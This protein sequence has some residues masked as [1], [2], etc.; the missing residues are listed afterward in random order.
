MKSITAGD[1]IQI[2]VTAKDD[3]SGIKEVKVK[4]T[5]IR[6]LPGCPTFEIEG[7]SEWNTEEGCDYIIVS[8]PIP[9][10]VP[11]SKW[12]VFSVTLINGTGRSIKYNPSK[13]FSPILFAV[14][15]KPG[16]DLTPAEL[17][18]VEMI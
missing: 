10:Y 17:I 8:L 2:K 11:D 12:K 1:S 5:N 3:Q 14:K 7:R 4:A 15:A 16:I 18:S 13:D 9:E 6:D